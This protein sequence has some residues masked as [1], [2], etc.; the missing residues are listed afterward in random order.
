MIT[1]CSFGG[2][3]QSLKDIPNGWSGRFGVFAIDVRHNFT[4]IDCTVSG[5][6]LNK[7]QKADIIGAGAVCSFLNGADANLTVI[8]LRISGTVGDSNQ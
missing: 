3:I 4:V 5:T 1:N 7:R 6:L 8:R 2:N